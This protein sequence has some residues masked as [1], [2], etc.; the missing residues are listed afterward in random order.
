M[1]LEAAKVTNTMVIA[2]AIAAG[3]A[4]ERTSFVWTLVV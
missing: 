3:A 4:F 2:T 1:C